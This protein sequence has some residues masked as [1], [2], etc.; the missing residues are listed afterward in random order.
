MSGSGLRNANP[1][2]SQDLDDGPVADRRR[3]RRAVPTQ[4]N[5]RSTQLAFQHSQRTL[6]AGLRMADTLRG[7]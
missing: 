5:V 6:E 2:E 3:E 1:A 7:A 4:A